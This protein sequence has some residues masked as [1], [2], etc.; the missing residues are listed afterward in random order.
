MVAYMKNKAL[1]KATLVRYI[2][3]AKVIQ[4]LKM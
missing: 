3:R 2:S 1:N 4:Q